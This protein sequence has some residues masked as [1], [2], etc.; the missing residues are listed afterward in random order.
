MLDPGD[1]RDQARAGAVAHLKLL[2]AP[3]QE[4][5]DRLIRLA[6]RLLAVPTALV[7]LFDSDRQFIL[8]QVGLEEPWASSRSTPHAHSLCR[9]VA[10]A[11]RP[12][13]IADA[14]GAAPAARPAGAEFGARAY[15]GVPV[16]LAGECIGALCAL[17]GVPREWT[18]Q[19]VCS[20]QDIA[21]MLA[22]ELELRTARLDRDRARA[23]L[24]DSEE[25][26]RLAFD[27]AAIGIVMVSLEPGR[28]GRLLHVNEAFCRFLGRT[29]ESLV[30]MAIE[31]VTHP[32]DREASRELIGALAARKRS[33]VRHLEKRYLHADGRTVWGALTTSEAAS[34][35]GGQAYVIALIED[36]TERKQADQDLPAIANVL[37]RILSGEDA[38]EAIVQAAVDI[39]GAS[40]SYLL[41]RD[42]A[43]QL[44]VTASAGLNLRGVQVPLGEPSATAH[45]YLSGEPMFMADPAESPLVSPELLELSGGRSVMWQ[46]IFRH[47]EVL[48]VLCVCWAERVSDLSTR[49]ARAV[50][51]L[52][53][54]TAVA[55]AHHEALQRLAAQATTDGLT[56]LPNRRAWEERLSRDI[57]SARRLQRPV[58]LALLDMDRFKHYNDT[59]GHAA[60]DDL[61]REFAAHASVLLREGD[62]LARWGGEEFA[63]LLPDCPSASFVESILD[64]VRAAVPAGQT[65]SVGYASW[66][67]LESAE[68][69]VMRADRALYRAKTM[70]RD[71]SASAEAEGGT[72]A[73]HRPLPRVSAA[74]SNPT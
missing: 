13:T 3:P 58:T 42:G 32:A 15:A 23:A 54:E 56:G 50:A 18:Q 28:A 38:R 19:D 53:D 2:D 30:G 31:D 7:S 37:R 51:L 16:F 47:E 62:T 36:V 71:R 33:L 64:R 4:S 35:D 21:A 5:F 57:A 48:G 65:C 27:A 67:G 68:Q 70:G 14:D 45:T 43:E 22:A 66:D 60:G 61:L 25:H 10:D 44:L 59:H 74:G 39:A 73:A 29:E 6:A 55:L 24:S 1:L 8:S 46:P 34:A 11:G 41:E 63:V 26:I 72:A 9:E 49:A 52:T 12:L 20:L 40:S 17:D 69:L